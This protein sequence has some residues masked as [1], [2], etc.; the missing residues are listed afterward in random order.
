MENLE[1]FNPVARADSLS[2]E[3]AKRLPDLRKRVIGLVWNFKIGGDVA[4]RRIAENL[5]TKLGHSFDVL[6]FSDEFPFAE[7]TID[8]IVEA[9][10]G[11]IGSTGDCGSCTSWLIHDLVQIERRGIPTVGLV[12]HPFKE[13]AEI[14]AQTFGMP[15]ARMAVLKS[16]TLT[17]LN[18]TQIF[19]AADDATDQVLDGL[20]KDIASEAVDA[21]KDSKPSYSTETFNGSDGTK[22]WEEFNRHFLDKGWGD[23]F[24]LIPP[25]QAKVND[26]LAGTSLDAEDVISLME[27]GMGVATVKIIAINAVMA[28][29]QPGHLPVLIAALKAMARPEYRLRTVAMSTGPHAPFMVVNGPMA[30]ELEVNCGRGALGPGKQSWSNTVLGRA[31]RLLLMNVGHSYVGTLDLDTIGSP[32]KYSMCIAE[33]EEASPWTPYHVS[34]GFQK[35]DSTVTMFGVESQLEIYDYKNHL[36]ENLLTTIAG[37]IKGIGALASRAWM[38]PRRKPHNSVLLCPDHANVIANAG[39]DKA[40][41]QAF[42]Y[43]KARIPAREFK[44][45]DDGKRIKAGWRWIMDAPDDTLIPIVADPESFNVI[46]VGGPS[47]KSAYTTG[48]GTSSIEKIDTY[49]KR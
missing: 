49:R 29:C 41:V 44:N 43:E 21:E 12:T 31:I 39:W 5:Q 46:V 11:V 20:T 13:D 22:A 47:G 4:M 26:M 10:D 34:R 48:V 36:P 14:T 33:N 27:P 3:A 23:G 28:G 8:K 42:L 38:Y 40:D 45:C 35:E 15:H 19:A 24:P 1:V 30:E 18:Q 6:E 7:S 25:T 9:C 16:D 2:V 37:T 32:N 17:N